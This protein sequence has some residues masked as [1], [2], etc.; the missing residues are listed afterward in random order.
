V[1]FKIIPDVPALRLPKELEPIHKKL[2]AY[3]LGESPVEGLTIE[4]RA[5]LRSRYI[6]LSANWNAA[7][8]MDSS[9]MNIVFI[10]RPA[11]KNQRVVHPNE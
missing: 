3:A 2:S 8:G 5:L 7:K 11:E 1:P 6:H 10:N 9:D 4:E